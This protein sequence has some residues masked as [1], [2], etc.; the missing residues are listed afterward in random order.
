MLDDL[1]PNQTEPEK[2][3]P[4]FFSANV[5]FHPIYISTVLFFVYNV[6]RVYFFLA[7]MSFSTSELIETAS[8]I[9]KEEAQNVANKMVQTFGIVQFFGVVFAPVNGMVIDYG[10]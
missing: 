1:T 2:K 3:L 7:T 9:P 6:F 8:N 10:M 5:V 4:P